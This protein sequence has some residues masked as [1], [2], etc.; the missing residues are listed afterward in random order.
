MGNPLI[1]SLDGIS[2]P[3]QTAHFRELQYPMIICQQVLVT[4]WMLG[5]MVF[6]KF[7]SV[8]APLTKQSGNLLAL[9]LKNLKCY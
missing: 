8:F 6:D 2:D 4:F 1:N 5:Q 9:P 7:F 3:V